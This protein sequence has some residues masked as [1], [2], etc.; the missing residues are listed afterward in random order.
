M[1][2]ESE[3]SYS[4]SLPPDQ[5]GGL[6]QEGGTDQPEP[7]DT[8]MPPAEAMCC[9][10]SFDITKDDIGDEV[11]CL[12]TAL[13]EC[14]EVRSKPA[15]KRR[16]EVVFRKLSPQD[17]ARFKQAMSKE[18]QSWL[19]NKVTSIVKARGVDR[20]RI[21]GSRWVLTWKTSADPDNKEVVP[22]ARLVLVGYQ[23]PD[24]GKIATDSPTLRKESKHIILSLCAAFGWTLWSA[25]IKTAFLSGDASCRNI[26]FRP[27]PEIREMMGL[28]NDDLFR[29]EKAAYGLAEAPRAWFLRLSRELKGIGLAVSTLDPCVFTLRNKKGKL[30]GVCGVH[31]DDLIGGGGPEMDACLACSVRS[32][33][34]ASFVQRPSSIRELKSG[35]MRTLALNLV[36]KHIL[37]RWTLFKCLES[38]PR[39]W[40]IRGSC[41]H[42]ADSWLG[43]LATVG[44]IRLSSLLTCKAFRIRRSADTYRCTTRLSG[45]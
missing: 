34:S 18:W 29:L 44:R 4:P 22:K 42:A 8:E 1:D 26:H 32:C 36:R 41:V 33:L 11:S 38:L 30:V 7:V 15:K 25:D 17:Q 10:I 27:P 13:A 20:S 24:L 39:I 14:A 2:T 45:R 3:L 16:V 31:V 21:I 43:S 19:E 9:E 35:N 6:G 12:W 5:E 40:R 23:D 37:R 28:S